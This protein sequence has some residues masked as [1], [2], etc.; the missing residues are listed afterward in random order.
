MPEENEEDVK[1]EILD[2][3]ENE[4]HGA[5]VDYESIVF[6]WKGKYQARLILELEKLDDGVV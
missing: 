3:V 6:E 1:Q 4:I 2:F 5:V